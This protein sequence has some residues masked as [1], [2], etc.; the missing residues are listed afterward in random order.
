MVKLTSI[1]GE[2]KLHDITLAPLFFHLNEESYPQIIKNFLYI[3]Y[4][5]KL[6]FQ[7]QI[8]KV[9]KRFKKLIIYFKV[10]YPL[11]IGYYKLEIQKD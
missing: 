5:P 2:I 4:F 8:K 6:D 11:G 9:K 3:N 1:T 10:M 7:I